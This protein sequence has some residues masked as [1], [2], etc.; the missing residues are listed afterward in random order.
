MLESLSKRP[1]KTVLI[2]TGSTCFRIDLAQ[3]T[4]GFDVIR[5]INDKE[6]STDS[7]EIDSFDDIYGDSLAEDDGAWIT[8]L[9]QT[10][11][12]PAREIKLL[13]VQVSSAVLEIPF[14]G[15]ESKD[16]AIALELEALTGLGVEESQWTWKPLPG[17]EGML[18]A[19]VAQSSFSQLMIWRNAVNAVGGCHLA[20]IFHPAGIPV[21]SPAQLEIWPRFIVYE[22]SSSERRNVRGWT[23]NEEAAFSDPAV[24]ESYERDELVIVASEGSAPNVF[25]DVAQI[26]LDSDAGRLKWAQEVAKGLD[27]LSKKLEKIPRL[28]IPKPEMTNKQ[29]GL[30]VAG[31]TALTVILIAGHLSY[32]N[33]T[34]NQLQE[35]VTS[36]RQSVNEVRDGR[37]QIQQLER[38]LARLREGTVDESFDLSTHKERM[39]T[40]LPAIANASNQEV[41]I[42]SIQ[43]KESIISISGVASTAQAPAEYVRQLNGDFSKSGWWATL[44]GREASFVNDN[45]GPW[46]FTIDLTPMKESGAPLAVTRRG[47]S[48]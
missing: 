33:S 43:S 22:A 44:T 24:I 17:Q 23:E 19:W 18:R 10:K 16:E 38:Q 5:V 32:L 41:V 31:I 21:D 26:R 40:L 6:A 29:L 39:A 30:R 8:R 37:N 7:A 28:G 47:A 35:D 25:R 20:A 48:Q 9:L 46:T 36:M 42:Q 27:P 3:S 11:P 45:G 14:L 1:S 13:S 12:R 4:G 2:D 15:D 34:R